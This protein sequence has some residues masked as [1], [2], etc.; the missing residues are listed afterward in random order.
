MSYNKKAHLRANIDAIRTVLALERDGRRATND[1]KKLMQGYSGFGGLKCVLNPANSLSDISS[2][3]KSELDLFPLVAELHRTIRDNTSSEKEYKRYFDSIRNSV[4]T[5]FYTPPEV[6]QAIGNAVKDKGIEVNRFL[7][8]SAGM[9]E[10]SRGFTS[11][12]GSSSIEKISFEKDLLT[13]KILSHIHSD[14]IVKVEGFE[15]IES[16][17]NNYFDVVSSNIPF[18]EINVFDP[19]FSKSKDKTLQQSTKS[20]HNYFFVKGVE[21]LREGGLMAFITSQGV[22]NSP[23]NEPVRRWL[24]ENTNLVSAIRLPNNLFTDYAGTEVGSDLIVLQKNTGKG[25]NQNFGEDLFVRSSPLP[26]TG[27]YNND[28]FYNHGRVVQTKAFIDTDPYGKPAQVFIHEGGIEGIADTMRKMLDVDLRDNLNVDLYNT[29]QAN[30]NVQKQSES[31]VNI[32]QSVHEE[33]PDIKEK[34]SYQALEVNVS[35][36]VMTLY[37][38]F[39]FTQEER[40]QIKPSKGK[41]RN[42]TLN[43]KPV[44]LSLFSKDE[45]KIAPPIEVPKLSMDIRPFTGDLQSFHKKGSLVEDN[46]QVGF[47]KERYRNGAEFQPLDLA[48][49]QKA[50]ISRYIEI[51]DIYHTLYN[52]EA[53]H[54]TE[55]ASLRSNLNL[56]YG[57]FVKRYGN[58][59]DKKNLDVIK[60]D[61]GGTQILSLE[62]S[63]DGKLQKADIFRHPVAFNPNELSVAGTAE[64]ALVA[65]LNKYGEID[66]NYMLSLMEGKDRDELIHDLGNRIYFNPLIQNYEIRDKFIAGNVIEKSEQIQQYLSMHPDDLHSQVSLK[67]LQDAIPEPIRYSDGLQP[68]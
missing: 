23:N 51:R 43:S 44:Q 58:L 29:H 9:G 1:E 47:L 39:G 45:K 11:T 6:V 32:I 62:R 37:D 40:T 57:N 25:E 14:D 27:I 19:A 53:E 13:G 12:S 18:G 54:L 56:C 36:P 34:T 20:I 68:G 2:W 16:R 5:A 21:S 65:S 48:F 10:F 17:Y 22:M 7:D 15:T 49:D 55:H 46:G 8:P 66:V 33:K 3:A 64:E 52:H 38:L 50:K 4:L 28:Y 26:I 24:M 35:E 41:K 30:N 60:M 31:K 61:N 67:A 42:S 59:N 63:V